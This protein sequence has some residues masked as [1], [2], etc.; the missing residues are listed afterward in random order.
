MNKLLS[1]FRK[2]KR[3]ETVYVVSGLPRSGTSMMMKMLEAGGMP[4]LVDNIREADDDNL[5]G[6]YEFEDVKSLKDGNNKWLAEAR[7]KVVKII[8]AHIPYLPSIYK[9]KIVTM[10]RAL[11][12]ILAS[13]KKMLIRR[14]EDPNKLSDQKATELYLQLL[15][16]VDNWI[17]KQS[18]IEHIEIDY[19]QMLADPEPQVK[20]LLDFLGQPMQARDLINIID[21]AM[22]R[23]RKSAQG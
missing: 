7:G 2:K 9:Y 22:Y 17:I 20:K 3:P 13:Q 11:P 6:Y 19:N 5:N 12:E 8:T 21:P 10:R 4:L 1:I 18:N 14:G 15:E 23:Q 16:Q